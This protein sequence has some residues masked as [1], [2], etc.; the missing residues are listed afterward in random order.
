MDNLPLVFLMFCFH[1]VASD[2]YGRTAAI[3]IFD[4][5]RFKDGHALAQV[6]K[7]INAVRM[8]SHAHCVKLYV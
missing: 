1:V 3:K 8:A 5:N 6:E 2:N 7:E 4:K